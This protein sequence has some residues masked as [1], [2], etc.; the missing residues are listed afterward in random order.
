MRRAITARRRLVSHRIFFNTVPGTTY[1]VEV[2]T[3]AE[4]LLPLSR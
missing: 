4:Q 1:L 2:A 3:A